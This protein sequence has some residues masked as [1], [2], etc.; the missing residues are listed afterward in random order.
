[1]ATK[2]VTREV[3]ADLSPDDWLYFEKRAMESGM[4][5]GR[6]LAT[7][8]LTRWIADQRAARQNGTA[9]APGVGPTHAA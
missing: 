7:Q 9:S 6:T 8:L 5:N 2:P 4:S 1:M 3:R